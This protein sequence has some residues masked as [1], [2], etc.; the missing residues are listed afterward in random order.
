L[1]IHDLNQ[2]FLS[3]NTLQLRAVVGATFLALWTT[4]PG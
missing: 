1:L 3:T 2:R 4:L